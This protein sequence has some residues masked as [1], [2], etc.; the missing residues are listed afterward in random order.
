M[1]SVKALAT[2]IEAMLIAYR[3]PFKKVKVESSLP[4]AYIVEKFGIAVAGIER[5]EYTIMLNR[6]Q[7]HF[8]GYNFVPITPE[9]NMLEKKDEVL[10]ELMRSGYIRHI[11]TAFPAQFKTLILEY[12]LGRKII[13]ERLRIW[14]EL[15]K[16]KY[17]VE[18]NQKALASTE[19][20]IMTSDPAFYDFMPSLALNQEGD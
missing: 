1:I 11:R 13:K 2:E 10:W 20:Y 17:L 9:E 8:P 15:P 12:G 5:V 16:Y 14:G 3:L 19:T 6:V 7:S 4:E 18:E